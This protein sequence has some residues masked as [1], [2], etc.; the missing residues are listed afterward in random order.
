MTPLALV[1]LFER[2][3]VGLNRFGIPELAM[4]CFNMLAGEGGQ[5]GWLNPVLLTFVSVPSRRI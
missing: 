2:D 1:R 3:E 4:F 5:H